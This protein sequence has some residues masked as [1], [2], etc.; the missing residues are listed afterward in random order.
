MD[1]KMG[2]LGGKVS[3]KRKEQYIVKDIWPDLSMIK[4]F[5]PLG[6]KTSLKNKIKLK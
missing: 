4:L 1:I 6:S 3:S 5:V 2:L